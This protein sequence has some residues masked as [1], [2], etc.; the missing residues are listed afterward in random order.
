MDTSIV[1]A[2]AAL[3]GAAVGGVTSGIAN[4]PNHRSQVRAQWIFHEKT[5]TAVSFTGIS[6]RK[7]PSVTSMRSSTPKPTFLAWSG[8]ST[9]R[10]RC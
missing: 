4:W 3:T 6:S 9:R 7:P 2:L 8:S 1:P 10:P 5:P